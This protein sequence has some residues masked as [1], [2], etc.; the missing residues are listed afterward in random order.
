MSAESPVR[1]LR[2][3]LLRIESG[4]SPV[5]ESREPGR[6]EWGVLGLG[7]VTSG[8]FLEDEAKKLPSSLP[9]REVLE[10]QA[11][12]VLIARANGSK[13][14]V[15]VG[16]VVPDGS[17]RRLLFPDLIYR[18]VPDPRLVDPQYLGLVV[19]APLFR[20]QVES[21]MRST[22]GQFKISKADLQDFV[23]PVP[24]IPHQRRIV[25][26]AAALGEQERAI[27][28]A[29]DKS[30]LIRQ[31]VARE[32][33]SRRETAVVAVEDVA[34][35]GSGSTPSRSRSDY[36]T[37]GTV[38][39]VRTAEIGFSVIHEASECVTRKAVV[40]TG[41]RVYP[42]GTVLLAMY[43]EGVTRGRSAV[44]GTHATVNQAAAAIVCNPQNIDYRYLYYWL[45][46]HYE[47]I[48]KIGQG[49]NQTN[50]NSALV[51]A[52]R[53]PLPSLDEQR[54]IVAPIEAFDAKL[55]SDVLELEKVRTLRRGVVNGLL[56]GKPRQLAA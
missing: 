37:E 55:K 24:D 52:I 54:R 3:V 12:D 28:A 34:V 10:V 13:R 6:A 26:V 29:I 36:W 23:V 21:A 47:G 40:E 48:R 7:A 46:R 56:L 15:G 53:L 1:T 5:C 51:S 16:V 11:R 9:P 18:L 45:E 43:G 35:V 22:S 4:W 50:L 25:E 49:S 42:P 32:L 39:W 38:P 31:E 17:R 19:A 27:E 2:E 30:R 41:L 8:V 33:L 14:L 20:H 44:L